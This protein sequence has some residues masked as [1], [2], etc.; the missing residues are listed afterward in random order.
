MRT[1]QEHDAFTF[2]RREDTMIRSFIEDAAA[3]VALGLFT[4]MLTVWAQAFQG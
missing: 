3:L 2:E 4:G 1:K